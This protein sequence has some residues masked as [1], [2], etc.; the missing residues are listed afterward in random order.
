MISD[1]PLG[2]FLSGGIDSSAIVAE[3]STVTDKLT[4]YT[5]GWTKEDLAHEIVPDD[6]G[7][8]FLA[9]SGHP[10]DTRAAGGMSPVGDR[11]VLARLAVPRAEVRDLPEPAAHPPE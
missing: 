8:R 5:L 11:V 9:G 1:V 6:L 10:E 7:W 3:A 4:T 2:S